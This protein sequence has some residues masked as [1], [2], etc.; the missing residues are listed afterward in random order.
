MGNFR[1]RK[2]LIFISMLLITTALLTITFNVSAVDMYY[3][4]YYP[5]VDSTITSLIQKY[6]FM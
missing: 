4:N 2:K 3:S 5:A 6:R 1:L